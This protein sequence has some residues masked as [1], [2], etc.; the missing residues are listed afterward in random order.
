MGVMTLN[1]FEVTPAT[2]LAHAVERYW[3]IEGAG[4]AV[5]RVFPDGHAELAI[6]LGDSVQGQSKC[7]L[8]GQMTQWVDLMPTG[9]LRVFGVRLKPEA[10]MAVAPVREQII[11]L[12][13]E[14]KG[15]TSW[16]EQLGNA[17]S[18]ASMVE[19]ANSFLR[20]KLQQW[21]PDQRVVAA[22]QL[23]SDGGCRV[24]QSAEHVALSR[25]QL[26]RLFLKSAGLEPKTFARIARFQKALHLERTCPAWNWTRIAQECGYYDQAHLIAA[27]RQYTGAAPTARP[28]SAMGSALAARQ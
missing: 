6:H 20:P 18:T 14:W 1:Y 27:F 17:R 3:F 7:L 22:V 11:D 10:A 2:D 4:D 21:Q 8:I 13:A 16:R 28:K 9:N 5:Q 24:D 23:L 25:R 15:A 12:S 26:E 19:I